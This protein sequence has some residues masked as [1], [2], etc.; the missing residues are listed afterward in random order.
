MAETNKLEKKL[1]RMTNK[2]KIN[3][4]NEHVYYVLNSQHYSD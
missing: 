2:F 1:L 4:K 3:K